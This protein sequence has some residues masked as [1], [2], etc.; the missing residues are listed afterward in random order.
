MDQIQNTQNNPLINAFHACIAVEH[1]HQ[2]ADMITSY[3]WL[4]NAVDQNGN[5][6]LNVAIANNC[7]QAANFLLNKGADYT[8]KNYLG[9]TPLMLAS[10]RGMSEFVVPLLHKDRAIINSQD[11]AGM[12]ASAHAARFGNLNTLEQLLV[13][14]ARMDVADNNGLT[15]LHYIPEQYKDVLVDILHFYSTEHGKLISK[16]YRRDEITQNDKDELY[17]LILHED[18]RLS[19]EQ[20]IELEQALLERFEP[21]AQAAESRPLRDMCGNIVYDDTGDIIYDDIGEP[22]LHDEEE[23]E[24]GDDDYEDEEEVAAEDS[25]GE[26]E[27]LEDLR[28]GELEDTESD[29]DSGDSDD[30]MDIGGAGAFPD[31]HFDSA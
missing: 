27:G 10:S 12:T 15:P 2:I 28:G 7:K 31:S 30:E 6:P 3:P 24:E 17:S 14:G 23:S 20:K 4:K 22:M 21:R 8:L 13:F 1:I 11:Y 19:Q 9:I 29:D 5:G 26:E 25:E 16:F 18:N